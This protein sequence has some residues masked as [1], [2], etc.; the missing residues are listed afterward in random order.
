LPNMTEVSSPNLFVEIGS[1]Y[2]AQADLKFL[3]SS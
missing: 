2:V 1:C 3:D